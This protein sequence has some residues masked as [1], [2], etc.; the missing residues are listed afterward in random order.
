[1]TTC[2]F[3]NIQ[4]FGEYQ[5]SYYSVQTTE[6]EQ[7]SQLIAGYIDII[8]KKARINSFMCL[9]F[10]KYSTFSCVVCFSSSP[11]LWR[12]FVLRVNS[13]QIT[14]C[15]MFN[16]C[17]VLCKCVLM[18]ACMFGPTETKQGP[19]WFGGRWGGHHVRGIRF[20]EKVRR[21]QILSPQW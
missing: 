5:E 21:V 8:L 15:T 10:I 18:Y 20:S 7:I 19:F 3:A 17:T 16:L 1:M 6:G 14:A 2:V 13:V 11:G 12:C 4:D 9:S